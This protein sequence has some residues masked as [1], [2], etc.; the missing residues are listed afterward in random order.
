M[1]NLLWVISYNPAVLLHVGLL[2]LG[3]TFLSL[4]TS[5]PTPRKASWIGSI[6]VTGSALTLTGFA[7]VILYW[8]FELWLLFFGGPYAIT[9][10]VTSWLMIHLR[11][12]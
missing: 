2:V 11:T 3:L 1:S 6:F 7:S 5:L 4:R 12:A 10:L 9:S 8:G